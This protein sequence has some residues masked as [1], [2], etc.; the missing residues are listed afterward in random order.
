MYFPYLRGRQFELI[1]LRE[2]V[3]KQLIGDK[4]LPIIEPVKPTSTL[5]TTLRIFD[6]NKYLHSLIINPKVGEYIEKCKSKKEEND[7]IVDKINENTK[8]DFFIPAYIINKHTSTIL[9]NI[10]DYSNIIAVNSKRDNLDTYLKL[11]SD[12]KPKFSLIP[13]DRTFSRKASNTV[14]F[15]DQFSKLARNKDYIENE[16]EFFSEDHLYFTNEG[17]SGFSDFSIV[18]S[19]YNESGFAPLAVAIH[20]VYF[21]K[22]KELRIHHFVSD[23]NNDTND[24][25]GKYGE[26]V[27][28]LYNWINK[29][30]PHITFGLSQLIN[31]Y[32]N[33]K[34][35]GLGT[36][37][38]YSI[39]HH[40]ELINKFL[41]GEI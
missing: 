19:E 21:N 15:E 30:N 40:I 38:K 31:S 2:L 33:G 26:A 27:E 32:E 28:K 35:P 3:E 8:S 4:I 24:P 14:I 23:S 17:F 39:M 20:I 16:D 25:A 1:A 7:S 5:N 6:K 18:G 37:K 10:N 29:N 11:F 36:V 9:E 34:Y 13:D 22:D 41:E 12:N